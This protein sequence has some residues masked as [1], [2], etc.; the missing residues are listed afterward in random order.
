MYWPRRLVVR[1]W[2][3]MVRTPLRIRSGLL[4]V[5]LQGVHHRRL[6][7][8]LIEEAAWYSFILLRALCVPLRGQ[9]VLFAF[10]ELAR[11]QLRQL[12]DVPAGHV[13]SVRR[14]QPQHLQLLAFLRHQI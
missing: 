12:V 10:G 6:V 13:A 2:W 11:V 8:R 7:G 9:D 3:I 5:A 1:R 14:H 4:A